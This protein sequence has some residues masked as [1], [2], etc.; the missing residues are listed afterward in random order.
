MAGKARTEAR[1]EMERSGSLPGEA[2][3][4]EGASSRNIAVV[5]ENRFVL[6]NAG[7]IASRSATDMLSKS[8]KRI[9]ARFAVLAIGMGVL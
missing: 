3:D 4:N 8:P 6:A 7:A 2:G 1:V 9:W 5:G